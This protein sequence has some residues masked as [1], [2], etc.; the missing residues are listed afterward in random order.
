[1]EIEIINFLE[2]TLGYIL[3]SIKQSNVAKNAKEEILNNF[4]KWIRPK[5]IDNIPEIENSS[6]SL[7]IKENLLELIKDETFFNELVIK[8][9]ELQIENITK[10]NTFEGSI[11]NVKKIMIGDKVYIPGEFYTYKNIVVGNIEEAEEFILGD[12]K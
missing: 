4:W 6:D 12:I 7:K 2:T 8:V 10:K 11:K 3:M 5:F 1:M 9:R